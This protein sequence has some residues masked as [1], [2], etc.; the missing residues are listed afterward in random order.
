V[1]T[2]KDTVQTQEQREVG[3]PE[4]DV[5]PGAVERAIEK[6]QRYLLKMQNEPG[7]WAGELT[8]DVT[9]AAGYIPFI[10]FMLGKVEP[11]RAKRVINYVISK[12]HTDGSWSTYHGGPG[13]LNVTI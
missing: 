7:Y 6:A 3:T 2:V 8:A 13:D 9:V 1:Q 10:Y 11:E 4:L 12:Q 5:D